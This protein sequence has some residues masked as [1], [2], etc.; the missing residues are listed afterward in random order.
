MDFRSKFSSKFRTVTFAVR[1]GFN[2][3]ASIVYI[4]IIGI[5]VAAIGIAIGAVRRIYVR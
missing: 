2:I 3:Y 5:F 1:T 4:S